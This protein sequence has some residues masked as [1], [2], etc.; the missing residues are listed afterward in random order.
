M[1]ALCAE[2]NLGGI[3]KDPLHRGMLTGKFTPASTFPKDDI[4]SETDFH[5]DRIVKRLGLVEALREPLTSDGRTMAQG[6]L[7]YIWALDE[8]MIPIPG[9][10]SVEQVQQ[11]AGAR[12]FGPL[13]EDEVWQVQEIVIQGTLQS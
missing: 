4:R 13:G 6:A 10:R 12:E 1:R 2:H 8:R 9:F 3:N 7:S 11:N 5:E